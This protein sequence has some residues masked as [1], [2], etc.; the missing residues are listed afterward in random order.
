MKVPPAALL[1]VILLLGFLTSSTVY[2]YSKSRQGSGNKSLLKAGFSAELPTVSMSESAKRVTEQTK[3]AEP[4]G[5]LSYP[6]NVYSVSPRETL[7]GIG[8]K[9]ALDWR[10]I[11][12]ANGVESENSIQV[13]DLLVIPRFDTSTD[14]YR[15]NFLIDEEEASKLSRE[16][17]ERNDDPSL[18]PIE[19]A[20]TSSPPY[21]GITAADEFTLIERDDSRGTA[22]VSVKNSTTANAVGLFQPKVKGKK[23]FWAVLYVEYRDSV[24]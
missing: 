7:F 4:K 24:R 12:L 1:T 21:F 20:K 14:Y 9:F 6:E 5:R 3:P 22:L 15:V 23:G 13:G 16:L 11:K 10:L 2:F 18:N 8:D 19:V 17:R